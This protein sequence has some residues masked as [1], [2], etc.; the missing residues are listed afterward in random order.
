VLTCLGLLALGCSPGERPIT[1]SGKVTYQGQPVTEGSVQ[2]ND[3]KTGRG[4]QFD[5]GT[6]GSY[7]GTLPPAEYAVI[8]LPPEL[9]VESRTGPPDF[10]Y[11]KVKNIPEKYRSTATSGLLA[12]VSADKAVHDFE[13]KP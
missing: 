5:L 8:I 9:K 1:V 4:G 12:A 13:M 7:Q 6:D 10:Q 3:P 11:K 2:F